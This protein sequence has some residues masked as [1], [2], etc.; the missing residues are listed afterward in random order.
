MA[1]RIKRQPWE[2]SKAQIKNSLHRMWLRSPERAFR[3]KE[4]H[5]TCEECKI[6][7]SVA[8][9]KEVKINVHHNNG[10]EW[11]KIVA[12]IRK[13][14]LVHPDKLTVLCKACH[15]KLHTGTE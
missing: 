10:V 7:Q 9:G 5:Y 6:K 2:S 1:K 12:Y 15:Q 3:M 4:E 8:K 11:D 13:E 14:L